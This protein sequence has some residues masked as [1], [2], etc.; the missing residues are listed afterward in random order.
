MQLKTKIII[1]KKTKQE[2]GK[3]KINKKAPKQISSLQKMNKKKE[4]IIQIGKPILSLINLDTE[5]KA[6]LKRIVG[7][8]SIVN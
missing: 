4:N 5:L 6:I 2:N 8:V 3:E 7:K 1:K